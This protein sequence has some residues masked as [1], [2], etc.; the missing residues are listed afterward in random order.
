MHYL[1]LSENVEKEVIQIMVN[2][3]GIDINHKG[4][5]AHNAI[6]CAAK[7]EVCKF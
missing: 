5:Q 3:L 2:D 4:N 1:H 7:N 6:M